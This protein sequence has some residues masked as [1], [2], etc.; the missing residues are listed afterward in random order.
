MSST[1]DLLPA[2][3]IVSARDGPMGLTAQSGVPVLAIA[4]Y[5]PSSSHIYEWANAGSNCFML[6]DIF[7]LQCTIRLL[8]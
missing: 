8:F 6:V 4:I 2:S 1:K 5:W 3:W 7:L